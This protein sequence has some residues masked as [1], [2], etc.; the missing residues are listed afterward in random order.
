MHALICPSLIILYWKRQ[1]DQCKNTETFGL[2][3]ESD[4]SLEVAEIM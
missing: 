2:N 1:I 4:V 3:I